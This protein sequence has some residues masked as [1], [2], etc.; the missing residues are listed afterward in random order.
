MF[1]AAPYFGILT[2]YGENS[3]HSILKYKYLYQN[4]NSIIYMYHQHQNDVEKL[5]LE[6]SFSQK[7]VMGRVDP[8]KI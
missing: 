5:S 8:T 7:F 2:S 1:I 4:I 6:N 3:T